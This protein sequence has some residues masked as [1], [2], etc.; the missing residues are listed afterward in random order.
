MS[1]EK[2]QFRIAELEVAK[3]LSDDTIVGIFRFDNPSRPK[4][5]PTLLVIADIRS[6]LYAYERL[7]D[8]LNAAA[9]RTRHLVSQVD[10]DPLARF[11]KLVQQL[12]ETA[13]GFVDEEATPLQWQRINIYIIELSEGHM[14]FTGTGRLMNTFLQKQT[15]GSFKAFDIFGSLE[16]PSQTDP[17]KPFASIICGDIRPGDMLIAGSSNLDR[18]RGELRIAERLTA[19]PP[20]TAAMELKHDLERRGIPDDFVAAIIACYENKLHEPQLKLELKKED[21]QEKNISTDSIHKLQE[22][23]DEAEHNLAPVLT[24]LDG[25]K[26]GKELAHK[27]LELMQDGSK[28]AI[29]FVKRLVKKREPADPVAM[30]SLRSMNAGYRNALT[31]KHKLI[32]A[33]IG[34]VLTGSI[35]G[36]YWWQ[37]SKRVAAEIAA[38][39]STYETAVDNRNRAESDLVY[40]NELRARNEI[41]QADKIISSL[42]SDQ[43]DADR[44]A[45]LDKVTQDLQGLKEKLKK[46]VKAENVSELYALPGGTPSG[47]LSGLILVNDSAYVADKAGGNILKISLSDKSIKPIG[48]PTGGEPVI[49]AN[50]GKDAVYFATSDGKLYSLSKT[51]DL[52]KPLNWS[53]TKTPVQDTYLYANRIYSLDANGNQIWRYNAVGGGFNGEVSYIKASDV[54]LNGAVS[55]AIDSNVYV[56][57]N[58]GQLMQFL[59]GGQV[60]FSLPTIDPPLRAASSLW[61]ET[62]SSLLV[63]TDSAEKRILVFDKSGALKA[64]ITSPEFH[65]LRDLS[66]DES[67]KRI[68]VI[69]GNRLLVVPLP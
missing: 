17:T 29:S 63:I 27:L 61:T 19:M 6:T 14:C 54:S 40:G 59:S 1:D 69:D 62:D 15:D 4:V 2:Q 35:I 67:G 51:T 24:P 43:N 5:G 60:S 64:Q 8:A 45:K 57:K 23:E 46:I 30:A 21:A 36:Y 38:W 22:T 9:E 10:Q 28:K 41:D 42:A 26:G 56:L 53:T 33:A 13:A 25:L 66:V 34:L 18:L 11:E 58:D 65:E 39:N 50:E 52:L 37:H 48:I 32:I 3:S 68:L 16:Q 55:L 12:N 20:V 44:K 49:S 47:S 7:L 31:K